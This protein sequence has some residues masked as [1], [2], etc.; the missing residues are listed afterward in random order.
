[1]KLLRISATGLPLFQ[2]ELVFSFI[3]QQRVQSN[4]KDSFFKFNGRV[5]FYL[6]N[7][8]AVIGINASGKTSV[9]KVILLALDI[10]NNEPINH[11][12]T[13]DIIGDSKKTVLVL[14]FLSDIDELCQLETHIESLKTETGN[15][16]RI[17]YE[18]L[19]IKPL[20]NAKT[21]ADLIDF[22][23]VEPSTTRSDSNVFLADDISIIIAYN[24]K[25]NHRICIYNLLSMTNVNVLPFT[26]DNSLEIIRFLDP[27]V[28]YLRFDESDKKTVHL[29]FRGKEEIVLYDPRELNSYLSSGTIKGIVVFSKG[30]QAILKGGYLI[31]DELENHFNKE[32]TATL[33]RFFLDSNINS[34]GG[35]LVF[36]THYVE[37]I[38]EFSR[39][40][41]IFVTRNNNGISVTP[42]NESLKRND[43]K[44]SDA[45]Q[46]D[47]IPGTA[48]SYEA[49]HILLKRLIS[50]VE[51]GGY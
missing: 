24:K 22:T 18:T 40:D 26:D 16:Y 12:K 32:I 41:C 44:K 49:Y 45:Y 30:I 21:K 43:I 46:S 20:K 23:N 3:S 9:L 42:M 31:V 51:T 36:S 13:K 39:N 48:P 6:S 50:A 28:D 37:I 1:M 47:M 38:D 25:N 10:L 17:S 8:N 34:K 15:H 14:H 7:A 2:S 5:P 35:T 33:I 27:T 4:D 19:K 11:C 29:K